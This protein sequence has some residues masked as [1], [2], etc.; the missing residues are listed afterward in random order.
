MN[1]SVVYFSPTNSTKKIVDLIAQDIAAD[2]TYFDITNYTTN[3]ENLVFGKKDFV[4]IGIPVYSGRV[5]RLVTDTL[6]SM[7]GNETPITLIATFGNRHY[8][9]ALLELKTIVQAN[10]FVA[11]A[12]AAFATEHSV[13]QKFGAGRPDDEDIK[14]IHQFAELVKNKINAWDNASHTDLNVKGNPKYRKYQSIP[15]KPHTTSSCTKCGLCAKNCPAGAIPMDRPKKT[16]KSKCITCMRCIRYCPQ[17][18]RGFYSIEK[19]LAEKSLAK[20]CIGYKKPE[21]FI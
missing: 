1:C 8:D 3:I 20:L 2:I 6:S 21:I 19:F 17:K 16:D 4:M 14:A 18:A 11:I 15:I 9:D 7:H 12:A 10:G 5:P 13:V